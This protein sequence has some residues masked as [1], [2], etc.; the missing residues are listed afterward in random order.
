MNP[1]DKISLIEM[2]YPD[3]EVLQQ[4][5]KQ[6]EKYKNNGVTE[7]KYQLK[8]LTRE[9]GTPKKKLT[10]HPLPLAHSKAISAT[11][12]F[13]K[14]NIQ[15]VNRKM[16]EL[17]KSPIITAGAIMPDACPAGQEIANIPVGGVVATKN[18][19]IPS[20]HSADI[21]CSMYATFYQSNTEIST[22]M[23]ALASVTRF[24][25]GR[26]HPDTHIHHPVL[27]ENIWKNK[28]LNG[29][30][31]YAQMHLADQGDGNHFA[32]IGEVTFSNE[33]I[34]LL[35]NAGYEKLATSLQKNNISN[36]Y[37]V[38]VTHH[39]SRGLGAHLYKRGQ[40]AAV[41]STKK[42]AENIPDAAAWLDMD[43][44]EGKEYWEALQYVSRWTKANH[45]CIHSHFLKKLRKK[46]VSSFGNAH[47]FVWQKLINGEQHYIHCKGATPAW[48]DEKNRPLLGLIPLNMAAPILITLG[49]NN[50]E[51]L[52][53]SPHGAGRN[54][55]RT[56]FKK[57]VTKH[58][59]I[60]EP[61]A[62]QTMIDKQLVGLDVR[63][64][65]G[66]PDITETPLAY[67]TP[68]QII[69]QIKE[70]NLAEIVALIKPLGSIMAGSE[71]IPYWKRKKE[72][73]TPKQIRQIKHRANRRT[74]RQNIKHKDT[75]ENSN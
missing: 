52:S 53:C 8:L 64:H 17:M 30:K 39:G 36:T 74:L 46:E 16:Q 3:G 25:P 15:A 56:A 67:K 51:Y 4:I 2:G 49:K 72:A 41:K 62:I 54:L 13:D 43:T 34:L 31:P 71:K 6:L 19:I 7:P 60:K 33:Q 70:F 27:E 47:N 57:Q 63:W 20:A 35:N 66:I 37:R 50:E 26:R 22:E 55:S 58:G 75:F 40:N 1:L 9:F 38:L 23:D 29:L 12:E 42:I 24:G 21:C 69:E 65:C 48:K 45:Q 5:L 10:L 73:L 44:T 28:F 61:N 14:K 59:I 11:N 68:K 18:A 32:V